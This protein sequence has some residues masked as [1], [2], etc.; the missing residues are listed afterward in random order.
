MSLSSSVTKRLVYEGHTVYFDKKLL[1]HGVI[2]WKE[3][4]DHLGESVTIYGE[5]KS[6]Y[7]DWKDYERFIAAYQMGANPKPTF[8]EIGESYPSKDLVKI[9]IWGQ[10]R[11]KFQRPPDVL[12]KDKVVVFTG[13]PYMYANITTVQISG[14]ESISIAEP[15]DALVYLD[16]TSDNPD[17]LLLYD[18]YVEVEK[19]EDC[20]PPRWESPLYGWHFD[21]DNG[22]LDYY[23]EGD[24]HLESEDR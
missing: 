2:H 5:V 22:W 13:K 9:V 3:A 14:P 23:P 10:D 21:E 20:P 11:A 19:D 18:G 16:E 4:K 6:T 12:F 17:Y 1:P 7:F 8:I 15:I 24:P